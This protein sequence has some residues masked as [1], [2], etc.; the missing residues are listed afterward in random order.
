M[1]RQCLWPQ[2]EIMIFPEVFCFSSPVN[3]NY[4]DMAA[5]PRCAVYH[6]Q[7]LGGLTE[8]QSVLLSCS[9]LLFPLTPKVLKGMF[10][11]VHPKLTLIKVVADNLGTSK[12]KY[13]YV[14]AAL[15]FY[16]VWDLYIWCTYIYYFIKNTLFYIL[17]IH[18]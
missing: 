10:C 6:G 5:A 14:Y 9:F 11:S 2:K 7:I 1:L 4:W 16:S 3:C 8:F 13:K 17:R 15:R 18:F 12:L